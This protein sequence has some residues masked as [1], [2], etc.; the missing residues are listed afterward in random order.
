[1]PVDKHGSVKVLPPLPPLTQPKGTK[2]KYF[3][4]AITKAIVNIF[5]EILHASSAA[6]YMKH[7]KQDFS[8]KAWVRVRWVDLGGGV[9]AKI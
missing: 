1:M 4:L 5:A 8:L 6:I 2:V 7:I 3:N 9:E